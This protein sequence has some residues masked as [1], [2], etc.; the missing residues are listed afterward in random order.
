MSSLPCFAGKVCKNVIGKCMGF[1]SQRDIMC[2]SAL[3]CKGWNVASQLPHVWTDVTITLTPASLR[4]EEWMGLVASKLTLNNN[5]GYVAEYGTVFPRV[6]DLRITGAMPSIASIGRA[7]GRQFPCLVTLSMAHSGQSAFVL[8]E[9]RTHYTGWEQCENLSSVSLSQDFPDD[10]TVNQRENMYNMF[11]RELAAHLVYMKS[12]T[13]LGMDT[14]KVPLDV[15]CMVFNNISSNV[16]H[17]EL[18][19]TCAMPLRT[20]G[21]RPENTFDGLK[22]LQSLEY[23]EVDPFYAMYGTS[24]GTIEGATDCFLSCVTS[25]KKLGVL[26]VPLE[27]TDNIDKLL[28]LPSL[29]SICIRWE[30]W[31]SIDPLTRVLS[32]LKITELTV[33]GFD[34]EFAPLLSLLPKLERLDIVGHVGQTDQL[35]EVHV[36]PFSAMKHVYLHPTLQ[37]LVLSNIVLNHDPRFEMVELSSSI[38]QLEMNGLTVKYPNSTFRCNKRKRQDT[39]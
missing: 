35:D 19:G 39:Q 12:L 13:T 6:T 11:A 21:V 37:D 36:T 24:R 34:T 1:L 33:V 26:C 32:G 16:E 23:L 27:C 8:S 30:N 7:I 17:I 22:R 10:E 28:E 14:D 5:F 18:G 29:V 2:G 31:C 38:T 20:S 15:I 4:P 9:P 25:C 3:V